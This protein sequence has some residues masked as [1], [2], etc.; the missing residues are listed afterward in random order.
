MLLYE[1]NLLHNLSAE[2]QEIIGVSQE[3]T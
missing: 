1:I 3:K 2:K